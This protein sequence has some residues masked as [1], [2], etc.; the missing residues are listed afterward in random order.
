MLLFFTVFQDLRLNLRN[1]FISYSE[2]VPP[3]DSRTFQIDIFSKIRHKGD[4]VYSE[5]L[6][7]NGL[8][9]R[10]KVYPVSIY[11]LVNRSCFFFCFFCFTHFL[12]FINEKAVC[13]SV[14]LT[15][16]QYFKCRINK[17]ALL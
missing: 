9:W 3:Y 15:T 13:S 6:N 7:V 17:N 4:P 1:N 11:C 12:P 8:S 14:F 2:I 10:L 16:W 5:P